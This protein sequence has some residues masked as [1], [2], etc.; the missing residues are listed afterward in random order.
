MRNAV[1][2]QTPMILAAFN[3]VP[4]HHGCEITLRDR[5]PAMCSITRDYEPLSDDG[6][7]R[8]VEGDWCLEWCRAQDAIQ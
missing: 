7:V 6:E 2:L 8:L 1:M 3:A 4:A 5:V